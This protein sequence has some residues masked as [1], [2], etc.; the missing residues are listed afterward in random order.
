MK[1]KK[2]A[3]A[4]LAIFILS[5]CAGGMQ[6]SAEAVEVQNVRVSDAFISQDG[7]TEYTFRI[8]QPIDADALAVVEAVPRAMSG[9][10]AKR[11]AEVLMP[12]AEFFEMTPTGEPM[13][14]DQLQKKIDL[15]SQYADAEALKVLYGREDPN[16]LAMVKEYLDIWNENLKDAPDRQEELCNWALKPERKYFNRKVEIGSRP[17]WEDK[18][19]LFAVTQVHGVDM[20]LSQFQTSWQED[21][22]GTLGFSRACGWDEL[23]DRVFRSQIC[24]TDKPTDAQMEEL[25]ALA[26]GWLDRMELGQWEVA[27]VK[28]REEKIGDATEYF[29]ILNAVPELNGRKTM[30]DSHGDYFNTRAIFMLSANG[31]LYDFALSCPIE[32]QGKVLNHM[33]LMPL[34]QLFKSARD[35]LSQKGE[36]EVFGAEAEKC[37]LAL[38]RENGEPILR[39]TEVT[40]VEV[41]LTQIRLPGVKNRVS[42]VPCV[43]LVGNSAYVGQE[44]GKTY[45]TGEKTVIAWFNTADG[46]VVKRYLESLIE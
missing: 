1:L 33:E 40:G 25:K 20:V 29:V 26:Q 8:D 28:L 46:A 11:V 13:S 6:N 12:E 2:L 35:Y 32:V 30:V 36:A 19:Y 18:D 41:R 38:E 31:E 45:E 14:K 43:G 9:A 16:D 17:V 44:S 21:A 10:D 34:D 4:M 23:E 24:R 22:Y 7:F 5:G 42:Y 39:K 3:C 15:Y 37:R 27:E